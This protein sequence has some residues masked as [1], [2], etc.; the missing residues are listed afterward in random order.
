MIVCFCGKE[1]DL[2]RKDCKC[3][4]NYCSS[5]CYKIAWNR[6]KNNLDLNL[7]VK[8][9]NKRGSGTTRK[10]G[11]KIV[12]INYKGIL[13][14]RLIM[15]KH[16]GRELK[17]KE[18]VHHKNG[19]RLDNRIEN[20]ELWSNNHPTGFRVEDKIDYSINFLQEYGYEVIQRRSA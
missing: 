4:K 10:N 18:T 6:K 2:D 12:K 19:D 7:P 11:Y 8:R 3:F 9:Y 13:E 20:L 14:H 1:I 16:L 17:D 15:S 5:N